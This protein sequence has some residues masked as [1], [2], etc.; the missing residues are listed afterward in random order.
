MLT[1][2]G[3]W[4]CGDVAMS[5]LRGLSHHFFHSRIRV[6]HRL[7]VLAFFDA[8]VIVLSLSCGTRPVTSNCVRFRTGF[9][10][11]VPFFLYC[12][13]KVGK[14]VWYQDDRRIRTQ[15]QGES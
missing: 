13:W 11:Y 7:I 14:R 6:C 5:L 15:E 3:H 12:K 4:H 10:F 1:V 8:N 2:G 9:L